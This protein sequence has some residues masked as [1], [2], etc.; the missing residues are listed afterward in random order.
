MMIGIV[1]MVWEC[2]SI[3]GPLRFDI[4][5]QEGGAFALHLGIG[6]VF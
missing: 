4:G 6:Q 1:V 2:D 5:F 3:I